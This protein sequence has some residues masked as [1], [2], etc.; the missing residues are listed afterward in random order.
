MKPWSERGIPIINDPSSENYQQNSDFWV[1]FR[2]ILLSVFAL[3]FGFLTW[4]GAVLPPSDKPGY[5]SQP[6]IRGHIPVGLEPGLFATKPS[7]VDKVV[8]L[9]PD[10]VVKLYC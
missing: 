4:S 5:N 9:L 2:L 3:Q 6:S 10:F 7:S 8:L 1:G